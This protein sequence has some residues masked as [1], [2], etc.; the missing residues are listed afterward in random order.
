MLLA[1][2]DAH[3]EIALA[4]QG[5]AARRIGQGYS[6]ANERLGARASELGP[7]GLHRGKRLAHCSKSAGPLKKN[8]CSKA[9]LAQFACAPR[10]FDP[11][12][13]NKG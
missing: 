11:I 13:N 5:V 12:T 2:F 8:C 10:G 4:G 1:S 7:K 9:H 6:D 3:Q